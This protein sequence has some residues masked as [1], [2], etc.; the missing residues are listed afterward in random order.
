MGR[1]SA[2][3]LGH[4]SMHFDVFAGMFSCNLSHAQLSFR[5]FVGLISVHEAA[6]V[7]LQ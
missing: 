6:G 7:M 4:A 1:C 5:L 3:F 2:S